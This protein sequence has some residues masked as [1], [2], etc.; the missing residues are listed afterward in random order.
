M[1]I[2][3]ISVQQ[4]SDELFKLTGRNYLFINKENVTL[5]ATPVTITKDKL[6]NADLVEPS[7]KEIERSSFAFVRDPETEAIL[8]EAKIISYNEAQ[9]QIVLVADATDSELLNELK[10]HKEDKNN[11]HE[12]TAEQV[13]LGNVD[14][15]SDLDKPISNAVQEA[16]DLKANVSDI[17]EKLPNPNTLTVNYNDE[18]MAVYD[19]SEGKIVD[20]IVNAETVPMSE[21]DET[22]IAEKIK[23]HEELIINFP[24]RTLQDK[25]YT[26]E[27]IFKWFGVADD[28]ELKKYISGKNP[29]YVKYGISLSYNPHYYKF[30]V[31]Y[32][33]YESANQLKLVFNGLNTRDDVAS[34]YTIIFNLDGTIIE[35]SNSNISIDILALEPEEQKALVLKINDSEVLNYNGD[36]EVIE[37]IVLNAETIPVSV[38]DATT[39]KEELDS[40]QDV[41]EGV[42]ATNRNLVMDRIS[43]ASNQM[44]LKVGDDIVAT[45]PAPPIMFT[46]QTTFVDNEIKSFYEELG[47]TPET[48]NGYDF[49]SSSDPSKGDINYFIEENGPYLVFTKM[50]VMNPLNLYGGNV[51]ILKDILPI[52][53][54]NPE[55]LTIQFN[56]STIDTYDGN[57]AKV[58]NIEAATK[59]YVQNLIDAVVNQRFLIVDELPTEDI[60]TNTIYLVLE[61]SE[62]QNDVYEEYVYINES[63]ELLGTTRIDLSNYL[64]KDN[65]EE[66]TPTSD[67]NPATKK[68]VDDAL[69][70]VY[71]KEEVDEKLELIVNF[72]LRSLKDQTYTKEEILGWFGVTTDAELKGYIAGQ[73]PIYVK[74]GILL[75]YNPH[76][77]KFPV[78]YIAYESANQIKMIFNGLDTS[79]DKVSKYEIILNLDGTLIEG[80][81]SNVGL[82]ITSLE[83]KE[84]LTLKINNQ[85]VLN[86]NGTEATEAD[87]SL[88]ADNIPISQSDNKTIAKSLEDK[89]DSVPGVIATTENLTMDRINDVSNQMRLKIGDDIVATFPAPPTTFTPNTTF[90]AKEIKT[91]YEELGL[92]PVTV[93]GYDFGSTSDPSGGDINYFTEENGPYLVFTTMDV[94]EPINLNGG[95]VILLKSILPT[96]LPNPNSLT[97]QFNGT[98]IASYDGSSAKTVNIEGVTEEQLTQAL[99]QESSARQKQDSLLE[100]EI[101]G[102]L[103]PSNIK[104]GD[105]INV[106]QSGL[107]VIISSAI[108]W[109]GT[110]DEEGNALAMFQK[111]YNQYIETHTLCPFIIFDSSSNPDIVDIFILTGL[112]DTDDQTTV[113]F[114]FNGFSANMLNYTATM[115][116]S[117]RRLYSCTRNDGN[118][119]NLTFVRQYSSNSMTPL[120]STDINMSMG[121]PI[122]NTVAF[123][124]TSDY[125]P[126]TKKYVD[127]LVSTISTLSFQVV[128]ELPTTDIQTNII[129]LVPSTTSSE[130]NVYD[131]YV[132]IN[133]TWE[134]IGST[135]VDLSNYLSK[136]NTTAY[137]PTGDYNPATKQYVD[138]SVTNQA[139]T[140]E[141]ISG[142]KTFTTLPESSVVPTADNQLVNKA[143]VDQ[144]FAQYQESLNTQ[145]SHLTQPTDLSDQLSKLTDITKEGE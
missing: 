63:W 73:N 9:N 112:A 116:S 59:E 142:L 17:P 7:W 95:Y 110:I 20:L 38:S 15:T 65:A 108:Y 118:L 127:G 50:D 8:T 69:D 30:P 35:G 34:K 98:D 85:E 71:T 27:E 21:T 91:Y 111:V 64:A 137:T 54:P 92:T 107:D 131:E 82:T 109:D 2:T 139:T 94:M 124:P 43:D 22:T 53:L 99:A 31:D 89:Q 14:N 130:Q 96:Y 143:Y 49:G 10:A 128:T 121:L 13:G 12:V 132:Y 114:L 125:H 68:Y 23:E 57:E 83:T 136:D 16:L 66:Y 77:Y 75:S 1:A 39:I 48:V 76:Y 119:T 45:F 145:F 25:V 18:E 32:I 78:D 62:E 56:G 81:N 113:R 102:K 106:E 134:K 5:D 11:P 6:L 86:Y 4:I 28:I 33:A 60:K 74:Y 117:H 104:A 80:T 105:G 115:V 144:L 47:F 138:S 67:Y 52:E 51:I 97:I 101:A 100:E 41:I 140:E 26:K 42:V 58:V 19:G 93:N 129:Y 84:A 36:T 40:K 29:I 135:S 3:K 46:P 126:A 87:I 79:N 90:V 88:Y 44:R 123:T 24:L 72:P 37:N 120:T 133:S 141:T 70:T 103:S 61:P 55:S 122:G